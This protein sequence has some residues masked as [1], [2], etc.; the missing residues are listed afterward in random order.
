M[1]APTWKKLF[2]ILIVIEDFANGVV[3][4]RHSKL[5]NLRR[6]T[7]GKHNS[8]STIASTPKLAAIHPT[9]RRN[10]TSLIVYRTR[11]TTKLQSFLEVVS[12]LT[13]KQELLSIYKV[14]TQDKFN[15]LY[16]L[17]VSSNN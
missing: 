11:N 17:I 16:A 7:K 14:A 12:G 13:G 9:S 15:F 6:Y 5:L 8:I 4:T 2:S 10:A 1:K 3:S